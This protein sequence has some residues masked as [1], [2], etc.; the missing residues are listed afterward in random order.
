[1]IT[2]HATNRHN[3]PSDIIICDNYPLTNFLNP[4]GNFLKG[5]IHEEKKWKKLGFCPDQ[6]GGLTES[7]LF[8]KISQ[9]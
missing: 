9:N 8:G 5:S 2:D 6:G 1:M 4:L 3:P 7:Q